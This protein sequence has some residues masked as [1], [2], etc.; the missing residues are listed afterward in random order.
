MIDLLRSVRVL[1]LLARERLAFEEGV[2]LSRQCA[3]R[4]NQVEA[5][6]EY[7][8]RNAEGEFAAEPFALVSEGGLAAAQ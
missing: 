3:E 1:A 7:L 8:V 6:I 2:D 5:R 4:L